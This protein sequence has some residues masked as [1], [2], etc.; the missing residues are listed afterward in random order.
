MEIDITIANCFPTFL[1]VIS[2][3]G[4]RLHKQSG[5]M[6]EKMADITSVLQETISNVKVVKAFAMEEFENKIPTR[7]I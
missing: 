3:I 5:I 2:T 4:L 7:N 1:I 6:Q